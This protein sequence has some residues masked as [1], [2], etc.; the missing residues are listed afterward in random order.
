[1][2]FNSACPAKLR[3][4]VHAL[5]GRG[6][7]CIREPIKIER[8]QAS[9]QVKR[10]KMYT[11]GTLVL[12]LLFSQAP[13]SRCK[14]ASTEFNVKPSGQVQREIVKLVSLHHA[15]FVIIGV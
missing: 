8:Y 1:M 2:C 4:V 5:A 14:E 3:A 10:E 9:V 15:H 13:L 12:I 6:T 7:F 11:A